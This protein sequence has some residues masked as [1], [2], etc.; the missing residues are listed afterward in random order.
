MVAV[1][2]NRC[3]IIIESDSQIAIQAITGK[4]K[5]PSL[6]SNIVNDIVVVVS[7]VTNI[8]FVKFAN[9]LIARKAF[10]AR[11]C[12]N[13]NNYLIRFS[14]CLVFPKRIKKIKRKT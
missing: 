9:R 13:Q 3:N 8:K 11:H 6:I 1:Q 10:L 7:P 2:D 5:C 12:T 4:V 14:L